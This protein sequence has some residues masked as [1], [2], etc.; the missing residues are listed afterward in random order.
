MLPIILGLI[1]GISICLCIENTK[2]FIQPFILFVFVFSLVVFFYLSIKNS[3]LSFIKK[4]P[5]KFLFETLIIGILTYIYCFILFYF[6]GIPIDQLLFIGFVLLFM[7]IHILLELGHAY[8][9]L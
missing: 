7:I 5:L 1:T 8:V 6:R 4:H 9:Y 3:Y 2:D